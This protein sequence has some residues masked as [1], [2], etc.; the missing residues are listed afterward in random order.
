VRGFWI[1]FFVTA[2]CHCSAQLTDS[3]RELFRHP[4]S[5]DARLESRNSFINNKLI[6]VSGVRLGLAFQRKL[7]FGAGVSWLKTAGNGWLK[8]N[9]KKD[10]Y[11]VNAFGQTDTVS[12]YLKLAYLCF[13]AD[14]VFFKIKRWQLSVP[15]QLG[16]GSLWFQENKNYSFRKTDK[17]HFLFLYEP[18]ITVQYKI[19]RWAG[20]GTDVAYRF[21]MQ[22]TGERLSSPS[23][24]FKALFWF[25]QLFYEVFPNSKITKKYGPAYW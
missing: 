4:Y 22:K 1:I 11:T 13:Y 2:Y 24:T 8:S 7:K 21:A 20:L 15:I 9:I 10:F 12:K 14:F 25:D 18:G 3:L 5:I 6:S 16:L 23:L 17:K 19:F